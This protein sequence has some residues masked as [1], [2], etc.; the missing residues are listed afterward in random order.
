MRRSSIFI[1]DLA[2]ALDALEVRDS[3]TAARIGE[4]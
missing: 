1:A 2:K 4:P 3:K